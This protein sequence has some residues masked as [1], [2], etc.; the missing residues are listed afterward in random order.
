MLSIL[1]NNPRGSP[2][3][4]EHRAVAS[5]VSRKLLLGLAL[6][7]LACAGLL[8]LAETGLGARS[9][10]SRPGDAERGLL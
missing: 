5:D 3:I 4:R 2:G 10:P 1:G 7:L 6:L 9:R 8:A